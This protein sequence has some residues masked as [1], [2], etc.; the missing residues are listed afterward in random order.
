MSDDDEVYFD[1]QKYLGMTKVCGACGRRNHEDVMVFC[2]VQK[3][4]FCKEIKGLYE[5]CHRHI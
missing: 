2:C 4:W 1:Y 3:I 5:S